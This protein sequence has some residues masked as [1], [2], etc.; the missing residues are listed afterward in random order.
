MSTWNMRPILTAEQKAK[1]ARIDALRKQIFDVLLKNGSGFLL[2]NGIDC[3]ETFQQ[4][5]DKEMEK[6]RQKLKG[7]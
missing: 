1:E 5:H 2:K 6:R 3:R 4:N 7:K